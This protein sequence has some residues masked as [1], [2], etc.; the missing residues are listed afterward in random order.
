MRRSYARHLSFLLEDDD[1]DKDLLESLKTAGKSIFKSAHPDPAKK[2]PRIPPEFNPKEWLTFL[3]HVDAELEHS[4][5]VQYLYAAY[6]LGGDQVPDKYREM[7]KGWQE[8]ILGIAKEEMG[9][10]VSV[11]NVLRVLGSPLNFNRQDFPW[12]SDLYPFEFKL[13]PLSKSSL[14]KYV[15]AES[16]AGWLKNTEGDDKETKE[17]KEEIK[18]YL[19]REQHGDPISKLFIQILNIIKDPELIP[20]DVFLANTYPCQAKFDEWGRGYTGGA[21]GNVRVDKTDASL[22]G[23]PDVLVAPVMSRTDA[24]AALTE[25][26]EQGEATTIDEEGN[27]SH[28]ERFLIIYKEW[29]KIPE[30]ELRP[31]R[32]MP[33]NPYVSDQ[34]INPDQ[35]PSEGL[36][37]DTANTLITDPVAADWA[38]LFNIRYR[39]LLAFLAHSFLLD[40]GFNNSGA[41]APRGTIVNA[42][43]G[44]MY[45]LRSI[46][47]VLVNTPIAE[48]SDMVAG[49]P[50]LIP[51]S[52][53]LPLG[54]QS[55]WKLH[56]DLLQA[57]EK[58]VEKLLKTS[59]EK[60]HRYLYALRESD[61]Q[62]NKIAE[63]ITSVPA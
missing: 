49:P 45:N 33:T 27:V 58:L 34:L 10:F 29:R 36:I 43:F 52:M 16:P 23:T 57:S 11:Q 41:Y 44:E 48:G 37:S 39:M 7:V 30:K 28:F 20:D 26:A 56:Q 4:L 15:F 14:A 63:K 6:S 24:I 61:D 22:K 32:N 2:G 38:S 3:L 55:R 17:I 1:E 40:D 21:R 50:F 9:H 8:V 47:N 54:E 35:S 53:D 25:I 42:T 46:A 60:Y 59:D 62:L 51:Y 12:D 5:M 13:E 19:N 18:G 31:T